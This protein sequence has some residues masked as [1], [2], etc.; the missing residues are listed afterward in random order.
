MS[1]D[2]PGFELPLRLFMG[3]RVLI[4]ELH[5][6]LA[7][8]GH[9][10]MRPMH[11]FVLQA[12]G[13]Q[14]ITAAELGR[15]LGVSKQAAG[16]TI[17]TIERIGYVERGTDPHD[18]RRKVVR[19]TERGF[20]CLARSARIFDDLRAAWAATLGEDRLRALEADLRTMTPSDV[21]R[22]DVPGWFGG[23]Q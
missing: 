13:T 21:F 7:R 17:D 3:F 20:D 19:L 5:A 15:R 11:G 8:Q 12:I 10:D 2:P 18:A 9:P 4:D 6:E 1:T 23:Y 22:I 14:G 16:K